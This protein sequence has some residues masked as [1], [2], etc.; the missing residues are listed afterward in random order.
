MLYDYEQITLTT[1]INL[2]ISTYTPPP[3][4][5]TSPVSRLAIYTNA[6][7]FDFYVRNYTKGLK[8]WQN[9]VNKNDS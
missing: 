2:K 8:Y 6:W 1:A 7:L 4:T 5:H 3:P 9:Y